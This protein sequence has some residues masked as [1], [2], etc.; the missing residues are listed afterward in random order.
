[1][2]RFRAGDDVRFLHGVATALDNG[3]P[4]EALGHMGKSPKAEEIALLLDRLPDVAAW[5]I[6]VSA[7]LVY[8]AIVLAIGLDPEDLSLINAGLRRSRVLR[9]GLVEGGPRLGESRRWIAPAQELVASHDRVNHPQIGPE[10]GAVR[11][12]EQE[13]AEGAERP[14]DG[15]EVGGEPLTLCPVA[16]R[17]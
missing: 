5:P 3:F 10:L 17:Q 7:L 15:Q 4:G 6:A 14:V 16:G 2:I 13:G 1:L 9:K 11:E 12:A 8:A